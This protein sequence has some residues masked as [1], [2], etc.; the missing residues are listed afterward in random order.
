MKILKFITVLA[1]AALMFGPV[2]TSVEAVPAVYQP[3]L[4]VRPF[5]GTAAG[6]PAISSAKFSVIDAPGGAFGGMMYVSEL[7][8]SAVVQV[9]PAGMVI[10][11][12]APFGPF[13]SGA[14][15]V[16]IDA[17]T[18]DLPHPTM[19]MYGGPA[20]M[21]V[22]EV[23]G[24]GIVNVMPG[25]PWVP[26]G[27]PLPGTGAAGLQFDRTPGFT[28]GGLMYVAD[29]GNDPTDGVMAVLPGGVSMPFAA[30]PNTD[31]RYLTFDSRLGLSPYGPSRLWVSSYGGSIFSVNPLGIANAPLA[32]GLGMGLEGLSFGHGDPIFGSDLYAGNVMTGAIDTI[33]PGGVVTPF[34]GG[35]GGAAYLQFVTSGPYA[36]GGQP[37][38][39]VD[40]GAGSIYVIT[41]TVI[42]APGAILLG[43][44]GIGFV[45]WLRRRR[46]L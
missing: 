11:Y 32:V 14:A 15:G 22:S 17:P 26:Y 46:T 36:L 34:A 4:S 44:I 3:G 23:S 25:G 30:L 29:W 6:G 7:G 19:G 43:G 28:Y 16:D 27:P 13:G 41:P 40:D 5:A 37:A 33:S 8:G 20:S 10:P 35:L 18:A 12:T 9:T 24:P 1:L 2:A 21:Y 38:L 31:P 42:P 39:Y 45:G